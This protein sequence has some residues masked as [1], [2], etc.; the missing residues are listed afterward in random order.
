MLLYYRYMPVSEIRPHKKKTPENV[1][2]AIPDHQQYYRHLL[3]RI[4]YTRFFPTVFLGILTVYYIDVNARLS[5]IQ[6]DHFL[7]ACVILI[8]IAITYTGIWHY[9][10]T[11]KLRNIIQKLDKQEEIS[12]DAVL[13]ARLS[14]DRFALDCSLVE[15]IFPP[16]TIIGPVTLYLAYSFDVK[17]FSLI[18]VAVG[19][20]LGIAAAV[21]FNY[22]ILERGA[23]PIQRLLITQF[24]TVP[25]SANLLL[26]LRTKLLI[27]FLIICLIT[28]SLI[29]IASYRQIVLTQSQ[30]AQAFGV[31]LMIISGS[32]LAMAVALSIL[33]ARSISEPIKEMAA[34]M[35]EIQKDSSSAAL[36]KRTFVIQND[37]MGILGSAFND[38]LSQLQDLN[39]NLE[40]KVVVR[41]EELRQANE[42]LLQLDKLKTSFFS[43]VS[44]EL[45]TP[46]TMLLA[47][48]SPLL[49]SRFGALPDKARDSLMTMQKNGLKLLKRINDL[50]DFAKLEAGKTRLRF[51]TIELV[52]WCATL[53]ETSRPLAERSGQK[54]LFE[55]NC[56]AVQIL[57]DPEQLEKVVL[58][59]VSNAI[60]FTP[61]A[62]KITIA[63]EEQEK[64]V[65]IHVT[66]TGRGIPKDYFS[67]NLRTFFAG[68]RVKITGS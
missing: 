26:S 20:F 25:Q 56:S 68:R 48:M 50:L 39:T 49:S 3:Y 14:I 16:L 64:S 46:L 33:L 35:N 11:R 47:P 62:G 28:A 34:I 17:P 36:S 10:R 45:R 59:L 44:H 61:S 27:P 40:S 55:S 22:F 15:I 42:K 67:K 12:A 38:M 18:H 63:V 2:A 58:N 30:L 60:K 13:S 23:K 32:V 43:N 66:D 1:M 24:S 6:F 29:G 5:T 4:I 57:A 31:H 65:L 37:E 19:G 8:S 51:E 9:H 41:T 21:L 54:L 7:T 52:S 53:A